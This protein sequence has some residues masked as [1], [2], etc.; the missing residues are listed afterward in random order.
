MSSEDFS[1]T[2]IRCLDRLEIDWKIV[3]NLSKIYWF[4]RYLYAY[5]LLLFIVGVCR[6]KLR[7]RKNHKIATHFVFFITLS[8]ALCTY[9]IPTHHVYSEFV[10][11]S[12]KL[13]TLYL[14]KNADMDTQKIQN[15]KKQ[16]IIR[17]DV[18]EKWQKTD[19]NGQQKKKLNQK[20]PMKRKKQKCLLA[21]AP[22]TQA[23]PERQHKHHQY[24]FMR[25]YG[26]EVVC[27]N[28]RFVI[29]NIF[30]RKKN[31]KKT[32]D[33]HK[34]RYTYIHAYIRIY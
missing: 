28:V 25:N 4:L 31:C 20:I 16:C 27:R 18:I 8:S 21:H 13:C 26:G 34:S 3:S 33:K 1:Q 30:T 9:R 11:I 2:N 19:R 7:Q 12:F 29:V 10:F 14:T 15:G 6:T 24:Q 32:Y 5:Q 22:S 23:P 17:S